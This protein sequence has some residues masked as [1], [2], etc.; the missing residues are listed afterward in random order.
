MTDPGAFGSGTARV[1]E[2][3]LEL[4]L[5][6]DWDIGCALTVD[7]GGAVVDYAASHTVTVTEFTL[8]STTYTEGIYDITQTY[9]PVNFADY[10]NGSGFIQVVSKPPTVILIK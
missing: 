3:T 2:G 10:F 5:S 4:D 1:T 9:G 6:M 8:G 7:S